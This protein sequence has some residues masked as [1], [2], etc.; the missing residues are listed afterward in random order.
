MT[1]N[2]APEQTGSNQSNRRIDL[3]KNAFELGRIEG[4]AGIGHVRV[5][6]NLGR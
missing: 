3:L 6:I 2:D 4:N 5:Q 1:A